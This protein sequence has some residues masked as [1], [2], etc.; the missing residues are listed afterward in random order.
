VPGA[1]YF[2]KPGS[3]LDIRK[4]KNPFSVESNA[5]WSP[6]HISPRLA[7]QDGLFT[8]SVNPLQPYDERVI[9]KVVI[10]AKAKQSVLE[11]LALYGV[12]SGSLFPGLD[13]VSRFIEDQHFLLKGMRDVEK[14]KAQ[15]EKSLLE[16]RK[17]E[18]R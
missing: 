11:A 3:T 2:A 8:I 10:R 1:V 12:H 6:A 15:I 17:A 13:G 18:I 9:T 14:V 4:I 5:T 16:E 7:A